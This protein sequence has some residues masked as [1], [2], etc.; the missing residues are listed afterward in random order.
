VEGYLEV[1][2]HWGSEKEIPKNAKEMLLSMD[3]ERSVP[4]MSDILGTPR[5]LSMIFMDRFFSVH[6]FRATPALV[7]KATDQDPLIRSRAFYYL[8]NLK[9]TRVLAACKE[10]LKDVSWRVRASA[11]RAIGQI[12]DKNRMDA[13]LPLKGLMEETIQKGDP[14]SF[15]EAMKE[16]E[17]RQ[18]FLSVAVRAVPL[19]YQEYKAAETS[20]TRLASM[21]NHWAEEI[22]GCLEH[23][24]ASIEDPAEVV[25]LILPSLDDPDPEVRRA[26]VYVL[27]QTQYEP[28]LPLVL[29]FLKADRLWVRDAAA[30]SLAL[31]GRAAIEPVAEAMN[32]EDAAF[33]ILAVDI[34]SRIGGDRAQSVIQTYT[35]DEDQNVRRTAEKAISRIGPKS[36]Q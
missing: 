30:L 14:S 22:I 23:W 34:L 19:T 12:L 15:I 7:E 35:G 32:K 11:I 31:F 13:L 18:E 17:K 5:T 8:G 21:A 25:R 20:P 3:P 6:A 2:G 36:Q 10:G 33:R 27:G 24:M 26:A 1:A 28:A 4:A 16:K 29:P 9:D